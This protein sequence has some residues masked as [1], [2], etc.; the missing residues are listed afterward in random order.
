MS[1]IRVN[2]YVPPERRQDIIDAAAEMR[3]PTTP[4]TQYPFAKMGVGDWFEWFPKEGEQL[5]VA[6]QRVRVA[7]G[8]RAERHGEKYSVVQDKEN[9]RVIVTRVPREDLPF[10]RQ[11]KT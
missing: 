3:G 6:A 4:R 2:V 11:N 5:R 9:G 7:A 10:H 1:N 8:K